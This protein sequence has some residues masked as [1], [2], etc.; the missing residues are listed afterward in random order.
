M[1]VTF[2]ILTYNHVDIISDAINAAL[3]QTYSPLQIIVSDDCSTDATWEV[4]K[5]TVSLYT[6][7]HKVEIRRNAVNLGISAHIN[8]LWKECSAKN[9]PELQNLPKGYRE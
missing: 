2:Y 8:A 9:N 4:I 3:A 7:P 5:N 6:G 1:L